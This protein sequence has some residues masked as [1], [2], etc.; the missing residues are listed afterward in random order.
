MFQINEDMMRDRHEELLRE[1][2]RN[3]LSATARR[4]SARWYYSYGLAITWLG[5]Q[6]CKWGNLLQ[7]RFRDGEMV[8]PSQSAKTSI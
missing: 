6:L 3:R 2:T 1:A 8:T 4:R 5:N 7:E